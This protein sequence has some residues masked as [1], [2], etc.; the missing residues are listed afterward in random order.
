[1]DKTQTVQQGAQVIWFDPDAFARID[2]DMFDPVWLAR[3]GCVTG[4]SQGRHQAHFLRLGG[5]DMVLRHYYRGGLVGRVIRDLF[6]REP[7]AQSRA[8]REFTL[9]HWMRGQGLPVPRPLA[10]RFHPMG[11]WYR[12]DLI[13][14]RIPRSRTLADHLAE[15]PLPQALWHQI[16]ATIARMHGLGVDHTDLNCRNILLDDQSQVW[17]IDFD[18]CRRRPPGAWS[19]A[20]LQRLKRS[21]DKQGFAAG[22][23]DWPALMAGHA[24]FT[25]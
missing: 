5:Q 3:N 13:M 1:M 24:T 20:N 4:Q 16:G 10:A 2:A 23:T 12:A 25:A 15:G 8:M 19:K 9:L 14:A 18:K 6:L 21:L 22:I 17:L 7:V 11:L